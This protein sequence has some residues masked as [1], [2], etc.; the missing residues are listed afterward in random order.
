MKNHIY[1]AEAAVLLRLC[2]PWPL[3]EAVD[4]CFVNLGVDR[5]L[6]VR[7]PSN[8]CCMFWRFLVQLHTAVEQHMLH[9]LYILSDFMW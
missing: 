4:W 7:E 9:T 2:V 6:C 8:V 5:L 1:C 3:T